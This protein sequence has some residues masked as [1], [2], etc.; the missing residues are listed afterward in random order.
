M[1]S[2]KLLPKI[3]DI[4]KYV[5]CYWFLEKELHDQSFNYPKLNPDPSSHLII[6]NLNHAYEYTHGSISQ[7]VI[8]GHWIFPHLKTFTMDHSNPFKI[9]GIKFKVGAFY[10]LN[11]HN[12]ISNLDK[13]EMVDVNHLI[14]SGSVDPRQLL[15]NAPEHESQVC[16]L[17]DETLLPW[18]LDS[19]EDKHSYLVRQIL[20]LLRE[21]L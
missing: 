14:G 18:L 13:I 7:N 9:I 16:N 17:L 20:L 4:A 12:F 8:G 2:W 10:S 6:A 21:W 3:E 11:L 5:E 1:K 19:H 15:I